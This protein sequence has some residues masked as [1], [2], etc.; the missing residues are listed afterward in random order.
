MVGNIK[1]DSFWKR[2]LRGKERKHLSRTPAYTLRDH[3]LAPYTGTDPY[4]TSQ[5]HK[6]LPHGDKD[7]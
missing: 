1:Q 5:A 3:G 4:P 6:A 7:I 2:V